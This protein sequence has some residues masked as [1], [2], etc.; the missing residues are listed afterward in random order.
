MTKLALSSLALLA[1]SADAAP[2]FTSTSGSGSAH[3]NANANANA[4]AAVSLSGN[5]DLKVFADAFVSSPFTDPKRER[6]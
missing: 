2:I 1:Y 4:N 5:T 3:A 6:S